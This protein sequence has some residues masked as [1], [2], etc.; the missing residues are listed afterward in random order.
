[1]VS[2]LDESESS[3]PPRTH[4][5]PVEDAPTCGGRA[6]NRVELSDSACSLATEK[7]QAVADEIKAS[8]GEAI[9]VAGDVTAD[10]FAPKIVKATIECVPLL[11]V[12]S[13]GDG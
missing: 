10:D 9:V 5:A 13:R 3:L 12:H 7:A 8:G 11:Q 1:M 2:D 4:A 6:R